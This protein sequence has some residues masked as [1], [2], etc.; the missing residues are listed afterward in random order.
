MEQA[1][2]A[3]S[4]TPSTGAAVRARI[5]YRDLDV[6]QLGAVYE[7]VLEY[8][9]TPSR[10]ANLTRTR[11]ARKSTGTFYTPRAVT[12]YLVRQT[13]APLTTDRSS[14]DLLSLRI[15]DPAMGSGA[16]LVAA[17]RYLADAVEEARMREGVW[18]PSDATAADRAALRRQIALLLPLR[19][20]SQPDGGAAREAVHLARHPCRRQAA[21]LPRSSP[22]CRQ[23]PRRCDAGRCAA[24]AEPRPALGS[25]FVHVA[26]L[27]R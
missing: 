20:R 1:V 25:T 27:R 24:S 10:P 18:H 7:H 14:H 9:P 2:L 19:R 16:F 4:T 23:Q 13:L 11:D 6:E 12:D 21:H 3:V 22:R 15:L 8:E 26:A 17:C 5:A